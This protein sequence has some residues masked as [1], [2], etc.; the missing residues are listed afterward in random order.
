M[1]GAR[2]TMTGYGSVPRYS[3]FHGGGISLALL[4]V[5]LP[6]PFDFLLKQNL[7]DLPITAILRGG[8]IALLIFRASIDP[9]A[10]LAVLVL[11]IAITAVLLFKNFDGNFGLPY[12]ILKIGFVVSLGMLLST[13]MQRPLALKLLK[14]FLVVYSINV[15]PILLG[16][17]FSIDAFATAATYR[18]GYSGL[19]PGAGNEAAI[20]LVILFTAIFVNNTR[21]N[22]LEFSELS[23]K[24]VFLS[25][26]LSCVFSG[27]K[28]A[29]L[30][31]FLVVLLWYFR[32]RKLWVFALMM[33]LA[34]AS[35]S[36]F[37]NQL[38]ETF[39][40]LVRYYNESGLLSAVLADRDTKLVEAGIG[41]STLDLLVGG[42]TRATN[43]EMDIMTVYFNLGLFCLALVC[44][45]F[46]RVSIFW[47]QDRVS[48]LYV[49][50][51][52]FCTFFVGHVFES[53]F[54]IVPLVT[55]AAILRDGS[56][57]PAREP[58]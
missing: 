7:A 22:L 16:V 24:L 36:W 37:A 38:L 42:A 20:L 57:L 55:L 9:T 14:Y 25:I 33:V 12:L 46:F 10:I 50:T 47:P 31:P 32:L 4:F 54:L 52:V 2:E 58:A 49:F 13:V 53:G 40:Y 45:M 11:L 43:L 3:R 28:L 41:I 27:S 21:G 44:V 48:F 34:I 51:I 17:I 5:L 8:L 29:T 15:I 35:V 23:S 39:S 18:F 19:L 56:Y 1:P 6:I 30:Y 26:F